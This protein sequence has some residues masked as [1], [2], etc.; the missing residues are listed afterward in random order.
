MF[1]VRL[2]LS[3]RFALMAGAVAVCANAWS[4]TVLENVGLLGMSREQLEP[5]LPGAQ[6]VRL[7]RRLSSGALG[8]LRVP[9]VLLEGSHFEQTLY[10]A[11]QRLEQMDLVLLIPGAGPG[12]DAAATQTQAALLQSLRA[13]LGPELAS[14]ATSPAT[15]PDSASWVSAGADVMLFRTGAPN[16]P[17]VRLVIRQRHLVDASEL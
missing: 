3:L 9:D 10:F 6:P 4:Q 11:H 16:R 5:A 8:F 15:L 12:T 17:T 2:S 7:P 14:F 13:K 1:P